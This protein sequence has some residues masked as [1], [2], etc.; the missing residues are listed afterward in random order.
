MFTEEDG[1]TINNNEDR[2]ELK[3]CL[4]KKKLTQFCN[5]KRARR[6]QHF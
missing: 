5:S 3:K 2:K 1:A 6:N 4:H